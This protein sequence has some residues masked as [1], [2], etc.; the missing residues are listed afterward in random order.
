MSEYLDRLYCTIHRAMQNYSRVFAVRVDLH[1]PQF[2]SSF[3]SE[4][5]TNEPLHLFIKSLRHQLQK[6]RVHKKRS[7][8]RVHDVSFEYVWARE[9][10]PD[11][12]KPHFHLLLLFSGNAF[13]TL[14]HFS[15]DYESLYNRI[16]VAWAGALKLYPHEGV[17]YVHFPIDAQYQLHLE[18]R[19]QLPEL[20]CRASYLAKVATKNFHDGFHVFG[21]SRR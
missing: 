10:G 2:Y 8:Q 1:F 19:G 14:G 5:L 9:Q 4:A 18:N 11:S 6:Y 13:N 3:E 7:G 21:G 15:N 12:G 16:G 20:F 17:Q